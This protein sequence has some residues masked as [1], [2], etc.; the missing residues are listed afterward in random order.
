MLKSSVARRW[1]LGGILFCVVVA[2]IWWVWAF[3]FR[4]PSPETTTK[5]T[6]GTTASD[7]S[8]QTSTS[9]FSVPVD[10]TTDTAT[11]A[12]TSSD[13]VWPA[14]T[15]TGSRGTATVV[16]TSAPIVSPPSDSSSPATNTPPTL[17]TVLPTADS[18]VANSTDA[19]RQYRA[20]VFSASATDKE[21][22][23]ITTP[24]SFH[25]SNTTA[26]CINAGI[27][28]CQN[29]I[30]GNNFTMDMP[31]SGICSGV[32]TI[33]LSDTYKFT[34]TVHDSGGLTDSH[35][36]DLTVTY[37]CVATPPALT[38]SS[39]VEQRV[40]TM[41]D[42]GSGAYWINDDKTAENWRAYQQLEF[43]A[44]AIDAK[45]NAITD[46]MAY[47]WQLVS[48]G[49]NATYG[50][51]TGL[52][53]QENTQGNNFLMN[54]TPGLVGGPEETYVFNVSVHDSY[55]NSTTKQVTFGVLPWDFQSSGQGN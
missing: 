25:W 24:A 17:T 54:L 28:L 33:D 23:V 19:G 3:A 7:S 14:T 32:E 49:C 44:T 18:Y 52:P 10:T 4:T 36:I 13:E 31:V 40:Y 16:V 9:S 6:S 1:I 22:G 46:P 5:D 51:S 8:P 26:N 37:H 35:A 20:L 55:G 34:L 29:E 2:V 12:S 48:G 39:P 27:N 15:Y 43:N 50:V 47:S 45:G 11:T 38:V 21:D 30:D 53:C 41:S 42:P